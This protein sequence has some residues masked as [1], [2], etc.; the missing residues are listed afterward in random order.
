MEPQTQQPKPQ[1]GIIAGLFAVIIIALAVPY[2]YN[3][4][5]TGSATG[6]FSGVDA[7]TPGASPASITPTRVSLKLLKQNVV[8]RGEIGMPALVGV[9]QNTTDRPLRYV[10]VKAEFIDKSGNLVATG[11]D[12]QGGLDPGE[13]WRFEILWPQDVDAK[14]GRIVEITGN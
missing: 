4:Q 13:K 8:A 7:L 2:C 5:S 3:Y 14:K 12:N 1:G 11:M 6:G 9:A 10:E